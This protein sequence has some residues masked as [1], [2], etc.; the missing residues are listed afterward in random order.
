MGHDG[1]NGS[2]LAAFEAA[3]HRSMVVASL[4]VIPV[5][6]SQAVVGDAS[7]WLTEPLRGARLLI[8]LIMAVD[9]SIRTYLAPRRLRFLLH[10]PV[11]LLAVTVPPVR[12]LREVVALRTIL[13][14]PGLVRFTAFVTATITGCALVVYATEH[15]H[16]GADIQSLGDAFWWAA[17]T[18]TT[19]GYGDQ[20]PVTSEG[21]AAALV[22]MLLGIALFSV[23]TA[24]I[25]AYFVS[26]ESSNDDAQQLADRLA[27]IEATLVSIQQQLGP[28]TEGVEQAEAG[29]R[30]APE[31]SR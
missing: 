10:H 4:A 8:H 23:L 7:P 19:V 26:G 12:A 18:A 28:P 27:R 17:V 25:A 6:V 20:V 14:R 11:D 1:G 15:D 3:T 24:H 13:L 31:E 22:L 21:R 2:R 30:L 29:R 16:Q 5:Y 9:I